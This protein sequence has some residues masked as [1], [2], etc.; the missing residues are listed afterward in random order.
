[1]LLQA[2]PSPDIWESLRKV[3]EEFGFNRCTWGTDWTRAVA[4]LNCEQGVEA[5]RIK[6]Q[7]SDAERAVLMGGALEKIY[8]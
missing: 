5:F 8:N 7:I 6:R 4:F 1:M 2:F 3:F